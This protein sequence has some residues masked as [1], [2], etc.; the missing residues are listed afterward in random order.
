MVPVSFDHPSMKNA[1]LI[2]LAV[3]ACCSLVFFITMIVLTTQ[4]TPRKQPRDLTQ[5]PS[6]SDAIPGT[7][8]EESTHVPDTKT[9]GA[10]ETFI[11]YVPSESGDIAV[12]I[13][14]PQ[15]ARYS[16]GA[17]VLVYTP[18]F[19]T[20]ERQFESNF[21][22]A[23]LGMI[24]LSPLYPGTTDKVSGVSSEGTFDYGGEQSVKAFRDVI[25]F[26]GGTLEDRD[27]LTIGERVSM[28]VLTKNIGIFAFSHPGIMSTNVMGYY[29]NELPNVRYV[30]NRESPT[31]D[32]LYPLE[33][34]HYDDGIAN[35]NP[36]YE[37][38]RDYSSKGI[39]LDYSTIAWNSE[40]DAPYFDL[41]HDSRPGSGDYIFGTQTPSM[42]GKRY[43]S[44]ALT[45]ALQTNGIF[46]VQTWP[47]DLA[48]P[49]D[50][51]RDWPYRET[52]NNYDAIGQLDDIHFMLIFS[53][54][55]HVLPAS[56]V[57][58]I[59]MAYDNLRENN[60]WTRLNPDQ[61]YVA[62]LHAAT[63]QKFTE[64]AANTEP[65]NWSNAA[66][67]GYELSGLATTI[68]SLA[69]VAE[70]ADRAHENMWSTNL[71]SVLT[72]YST[73]LTAPTSTKTTAPTGANK[74]RR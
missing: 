33:I 49:E 74:P 11:A 52:I 39:D 23:A 45:S 15:T 53:T 66:A 31:V 12:Q 43:Y 44:E 25:K 72:S 14:V 21:D 18:V 70:M 73:S 69:G 17:P 1:P 71:S 22:A 30:V 60:V 63:G 8:D 40:T 54:K 7:D 5:V 47:S 36:A 37:Y 64:R 9:Y 32:T 26:A 29:G 67:E 27:S 16:D 20:S 19:F 46:T 6:Q 42:F 4:S 24:L 62:A 65:S 59:H 10:G 41:N 34:G 51:A 50:T 3:L 56:D 2:G 55:G 61:S 57:P 28:P 13:T 58:E 35:N 68:M 48:T 38:S